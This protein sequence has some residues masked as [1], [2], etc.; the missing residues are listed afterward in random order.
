MNTP[1]ILT[2]M[3]LAIGVFLVAPSV[4]DN[5]VVVVDLLF[6]QGSTV[7]RPPPA[8]EIFHAA[9]P[10]Q[11]PATSELILGILLILLGLGIYTF[12]SV[13][14]RTLPHTPKH[15]KTITLV[16]SPSRWFWIG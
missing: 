16:R 8:E 9:A 12:W 15:T 2:A 6:G 3:I 4:L 1:R 10:A 5:S 7:I 13:R 11:N 14:S